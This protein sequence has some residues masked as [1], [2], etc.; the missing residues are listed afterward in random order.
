MSLKAKQKKRIRR[1]KRVRAKLLGTTS[2][3]RISVFR[4]SRHLHLQLID[5]IKG[6]TL[7]SA[8]TVKMVK[9]SDRL[10]ELGKAFAAGLKKKG[11][12]VAVFDRGG[13]Q[14]HGQ[15]KKIAEILRESGIK[16]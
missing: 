10:E 4:S 9:K 16:I 12:A 3:P 13:Y 7:V 6:Q 8:S 2:R 15:I 11:I 14:Y 1:H 5:D